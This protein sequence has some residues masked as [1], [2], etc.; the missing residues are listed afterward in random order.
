MKCSVRENEVL[1]TPYRLHSIGK[2]KHEKQKKKQRDYIG[3]YYYYLHFTIVSLSI[4]VNPAPTKADRICF[5]VGGGANDD[6]DDDDNAGDIV[7][8]CWFIGCFGL[9][10]SCLFATSFSGLGLIVFFPCYLVG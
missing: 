1:E 6:D 4:L 3:N 8:F 10:C 7:A 2:S 9:L 5:L